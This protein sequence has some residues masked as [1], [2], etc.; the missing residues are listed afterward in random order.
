MTGGSALS[1]TTF[2]GISHGDPQAAKYLTSFYD[3]KKEH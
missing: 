1:D 3:G 2:N